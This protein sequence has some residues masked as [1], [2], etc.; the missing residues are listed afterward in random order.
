[1]LADEIRRLLEASPLAGQTKKVMAHVQPAVRFHS[2]L[3]EVGDL[4]LGASRMGGAPDLPP[5]LPWPEIKGRPIEFLAQIDLAA[6]AR[7]FPLPG[8]PTA[9]WLAVFSDSKQIYEGVWE[10]RRFWQLI[11]F[12]GEAAELVRRE[13]PG[14]PR[15]Y[16]N[17]CELKFEREDCVP[18][19][20]DLVP[21]DLLGDDTWEVCRD[22][23]ERINEAKDW[24]PVHRL[25]GYPMLI[26]TFLEDYAGWRFL[27]QIDS[28]AEP[29]WMWGDAG[30]LYFWISQEDLAAG[31][32]H[33]IHCGE[34]FY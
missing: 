20:S 33:D 29:G 12:E 24:R 9:G 5:G 1:M 6:A 10:D 27:L 18:D 23:N 8:L 34:E 32:F 2:Y 25:G 28:D 22:L 31:V 4:P 19:L 3:M 16:F 17:L 26:Q 15:D 13:Y 11:Y 21:N 30:R 7:A 14:E